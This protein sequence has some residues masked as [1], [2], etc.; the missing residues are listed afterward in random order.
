MY[1]NEKIDAIKKWLGSGSINTFGRP[2]AGKDSQCHKL[3]GIFE[4][5]VLGAGD[6][7]R[8][9]NMPE[10]VKRCMRTGELVPYEDFVNI[11]LPVLSQEKF[12]NMPL[13]L[14]SIGRWHG[15][16]GGVVSAL[17]RSN[18]ELKAVIYLDI[19][20]EESLNRRSIS[21]KIN[22]RNSRADDDAKIM[23]TRFKE[24][25]YKTLPVIDYYQDLGIL[26]K[27]DGKGPRDEITNNIIDSLYEHT[28]HV[29]TSQ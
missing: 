17:D 23:D 3:A 27:I 21:E 29:S 6:I 25:N 20:N 15:E 22:D 2:F 12:D 19:S 14:D 13:I 4:C 8:G 9:E 7:F 11:I 26:I 1:D 18:H 5:P 16:E 24:F 28:S 10:S